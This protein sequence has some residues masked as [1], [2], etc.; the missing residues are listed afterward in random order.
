MVQEPEDVLVKRGVFSV[1]RIV[2][3][4]WGE[5]ADTNVVKYVAKLKTGKSLMMGREST[6]RS[7]GTWNEELVL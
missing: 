7:R 2:L 3:R 5:C 6:Q 4:H 1:E